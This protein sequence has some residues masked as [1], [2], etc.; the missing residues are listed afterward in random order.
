MNRNVNAVLNL[1]NIVSHPLFSWLVVGSE[2]LADDSA[3]Q[4][5]GIALRGRSIDL[6]HGETGLKS[7]RKIWGLM[8]PLV[9][10]DKSYD[11][12]NRKELRE[13]F[14]LAVNPG[15]RQAPGWSGTPA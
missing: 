4:I 2:R 5:F 15:H 11:F 7:L 8:G 9:S 12:N 6:A 10:K 1:R 3:R 14:A 13:I